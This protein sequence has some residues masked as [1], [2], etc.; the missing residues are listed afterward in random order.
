MLVGWV[1]A[2]N[3]TNQQIKLGFPEIKPIDT[4]INK[5]YHIMYGRADIMRPVER[6]H[7]L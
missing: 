6:F 3:P 4:H 7:I 5:N 1:D 2:G